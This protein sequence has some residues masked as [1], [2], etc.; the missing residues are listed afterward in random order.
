MQPAA[1]DTQETNN[2]IT[3]TAPQQ[4]TPVYSGTQVWE[5]LASYLLLKL[6]FIVGS[7]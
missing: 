6:F 4:F 7:I 2:F 5:L 3:L 1:S